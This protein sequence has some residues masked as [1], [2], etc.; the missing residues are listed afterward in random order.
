MLSG[1]R[2]E[3]RVADSRRRARS[4]QHAA[5]LAAQAASDDPDWAP[6]EELMSAFALQAGR[7]ALDLA[8]VERDLALGG[9]AA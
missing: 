1:D 2:T 8:V 6:N 4:L 5:Q 7:I 3:G 9:E